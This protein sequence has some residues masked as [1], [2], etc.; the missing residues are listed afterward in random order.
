MT[1]NPNC[2]H[3]EFGNRTIFADCYTKDET[4]ILTKSVVYR[5][6]ELRRFDLARFLL[7]RAIHL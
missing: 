7:P 5:K 6:N 1:L 3:L 4:F 2:N